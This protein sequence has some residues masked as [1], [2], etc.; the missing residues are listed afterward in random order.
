MVDE[1]KRYEARLDLCPCNEK[2]RIYIKCRCDTE[3]TAFWPE[4]LFRPGTSLSF[5]CSNPDCP[6]E[7]NVS[8][9]RSTG[10]YSINWT[11][12]EGDLIKVPGPLFQEFLSHDY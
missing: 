8:R 4:E 1:N 6:N 3:I 2:I 12:K 9:D 10:S 7:Y 11:R 5:P